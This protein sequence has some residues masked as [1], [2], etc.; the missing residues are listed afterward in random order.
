MVVM[1]VVVQPKVMAAYKEWDEVSVC[2][3][4]KAKGSSALFSNFVQ[5]KDQQAR[6][7]KLSEEFL[8]LTLEESS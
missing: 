3:Q 1:V 6:L 5:K 2:S 8:S 4:S 7:L